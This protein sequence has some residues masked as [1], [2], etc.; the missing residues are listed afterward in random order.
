[1]RNYFP[2]C[3]LHGHRFKE[4]NAQTFEKDLV[5]ELNDHTFRFRD[6][7]TLRYEILNCGHLVFFNFKVLVLVIVICF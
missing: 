3:I 7:Y 6:R 2:D 5:E 4:V 1:M